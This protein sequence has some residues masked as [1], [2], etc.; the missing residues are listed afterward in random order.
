MFRAV[1][2]FW[3]VLGYDADFWR[4]PVILGALLAGLTW[5][6]WYFTKVPCTF[7]NAASGLCNPSVVASF[8]NADIASRCTGAWLGATTLT[9]GINAIM[10]SRER[11][12]TEEANRRADEERKRAD[13]ERRRAEERIEALINE[14]RDERRQADERLDEERR[15][16]AE[17]VAEERRLAA[18]E[19]R[20]L[21]ATITEL[22]GAITE[23]RRENGSNNGS[24]N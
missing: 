13:D 23:L 7:D 24:E 21:M 14:L 5:L 12:R 1:R 20:I 8:I 9:G 6:V 10:L 11:E 4:G 22:T 18:E 3:D 17:R 16:A 15:E 19:R 2:R